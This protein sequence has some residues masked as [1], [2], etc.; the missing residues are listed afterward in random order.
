MPGIG[1]RGALSPLT[2]KPENNEGGGSH[3]VL[4]FPAE[5]VL[6]KPVLHDLQVTP[7]HSIPKTPPTCLLHQGIVTRIIHFEVAGIS[8]LLLLSSV[9]LI[10]GAIPQ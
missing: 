4:S 10:P 3:S 2:N 7:P 8:P 5:S 1:A 9:E 6:G